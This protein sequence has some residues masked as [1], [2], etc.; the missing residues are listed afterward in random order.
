MFAKAGKEFLD[1]SKSL[2]QVAVLTEGAVDIEKLRDQA[3]DLAANGFGTATDAV[4]A[5]YQAL[6]AGQTEE[7]AK[8]LT[9]VA[10]KL[11]GLGAAAGDTVTTTQ[12]MDLLTTAI[13]GFG[14]SAGDAT[15]IADLL[16]T[17]VKEGKTSIGEMASTFSTAAPL[18]NALGLGIKDVLIPLD[19]MTQQGTDSATAMTQL[20]AV[21]QSMQKP[22]EELRQVMIAMGSE[23]AT[24]LFDKFGGFIPTLIALQQETENQNQRFV[25]MFPNVR[26]LQ[27]A[28]QVL[29]Q[30]GQMATDTAKKFSGA[31]GTMAKQ[32]EIFAKTP[33]TKFASALSQIKNLFIGIIESLNGSVGIINLFK[34]MIATMAAFK[35]GALIAK[36]ATLIA[37][38][39]A[40]AVAKTA[41]QTGIGALGAVPAVLGVIGAGIAAAGAIYAANAAFNIKSPKATT[42]VPAKKELPNIN[43]MTNV[44]LNQEDGETTS[45]SPNTNVHS[46]TGGNRG[47]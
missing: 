7:E 25:D 28:L 4:N 42:G 20:R 33:A 44:Y 18:A 31:T 16:L 29:N 26:A 39:T 8:K 46:G 1:M 6:S 38:F 23:D 15:E 41:A 9:D 14:K 2:R 13:N 10:S 24:V 19:V 36:I 47:S 17:S 35:V 3:K 40:L 12:A 5:F 37:S 30:N 11:A 27:G 45:N 34:I 22:T 43:N 21:M 32:A